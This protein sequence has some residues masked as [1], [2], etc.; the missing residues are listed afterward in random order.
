[1][2]KNTNIQTKQHKH[3][4]PQLGFQTKT[5]VKAGPAIGIQMKPD[6]TLVYTPTRS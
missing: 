1:M 3:R 4:K 6:G 2:K 5:R